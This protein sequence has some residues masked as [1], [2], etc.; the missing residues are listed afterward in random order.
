MALTWKLI[1]RMSIASFFGLLLQWGTTGGALLIVYFTPTVGKLAVSSLALKLMQPSCCHSTGFDCRSLS[2]ITYAGASTVVWLVLL[3]STD[4]RR[5][6]WPTWISH[7]LA[8]L[9]TCLAACNTFWAVV[10]SFLQFAH[11]WSNCW[12]DSCVLGR[13]GITSAFNVFDPTKDDILAAK[14]KWSTGLITA[15]GSAILFV[16]FVCCDRRPRTIQ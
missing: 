13:R 7:G 5:R 14:I 2:Y 11:V 6:Q 10:L 3:I 15:M 1:A 12:C 8:L 9:G 16:F 4:A